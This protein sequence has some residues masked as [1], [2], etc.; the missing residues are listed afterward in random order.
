MPTSVVAAEFSGFLAS[1]R[2]QEPTTVTV[3]VRGHDDLLGH[4]QTIA[5]ALR[6]LVGVWDCDAAGV[7]GEMYGS[8]FVQT[9]VNPGKSSVYGEA[10]DLDAHR[11]GHLS[12]EQRDRLNSLGWRDPKVEVMPYEDAEYAVEWDC[13]FVREWPLPEIRLSEI[14]ADFALTLRTVY[15]LQ[16][17][18]DLDVTL[19]RYPDDDGDGSGSTPEPAGHLIPVA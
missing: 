5:T 10:V 15:G 9:L 13:N 3:L 14:A 4:R 12:A 19:I 6:E 8:S 18:N 17:L 7:F 2:D 1:V 11:C 16:P